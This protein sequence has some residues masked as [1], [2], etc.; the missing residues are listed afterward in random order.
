M[1]V[2]T[3][4]TF[5]EL[6]MSFLALP[7][8]LEIQAELH[9]TRTFLERTMDALVKLHFALA[10]AVL[11]ETQADTEADLHGTRIFLE[12]TMDTLVKVH[13]LLKLAVMLEN[14]V[15]A[16]MLE[17][18]LLEIIMLE[19]TMLDTANCSHSLPLKTVK[20]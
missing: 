17:A 14:Q 8:L 13:F 1:I 4:P 12:R 5:T 15:D 3:P 9:A 10:L 20:R 2:L 18:A 7:A 16:I 19:T 11:L 6:S